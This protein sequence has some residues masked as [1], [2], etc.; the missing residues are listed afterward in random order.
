[1]NFIFKKEMSSDSWETALAA[2]L[3]ALEKIFFHQF[4]WGNHR[5][6][7]LA[8]QFGI[9]PAATQEFLERATFKVACLAAKQE[10]ID[11]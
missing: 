11:A 2:N 5:I 1:M 10:V 4:F 6:E 9:S 3:T 8:A 7:G